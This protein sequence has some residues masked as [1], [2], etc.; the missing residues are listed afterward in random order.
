MNRLLL[1]AILI[2]VPAELLRG[3]PLPSVQEVTSRMEARYEMIDDARASFTQTVVLGYAS[4]TQTF[5]GTILFKKPKQYRLES[6]HQTIV[7]DGSTVWAYV[8]ANAQVIID[9]YKEQR[10]SV[11]PDEFLLTLPATYYSTVIGREDG[12]EGPLLLLKLTPKDDRSFVRTVRLW[13]LESSMEVRRIQIIDQNETETTYA[14]SSV[15]LNSGIDDATFRFAA[16]QGTEVV[17]LR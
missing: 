14:I 4:I 16:P 3:Q 13:L 9:T 10:N 1:I 8:P 2:L 5:D 11:S 6:E 17:D 15:R 7:T 12:P